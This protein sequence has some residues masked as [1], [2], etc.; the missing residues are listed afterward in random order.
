MMDGIQLCSGA[1]SLDVNEDGKLDMVLTFFNGNDAWWFPNLGGGNFDAPKALFN[2]L[3]SPTNVHQTMLTDL[4]ADGRIDYI[5]S[6]KTTTLTK[7]AWFRNLGN[8][9]FDAEKTLVSMGHQGS[10]ATPYFTVFDATL[11]GLPDLVVSDNYW[12]RFHLL[13]SAGNG[14]FSASKVVYDEGDFGDFYGVVGHDVDGDGRLDLVYGNRTENIN[15]QGYE[16]LSWLRNLHPQPVVPFSVIEKSATCSDNQTPADAT[17]DFLTISLKIKG[18]DNSSTRFVLSNFKTGAV[19]DTFIYDEKIELQLPPGS[20]GD[21]VL[22]E[23]KIQDLIFQ[24]TFLV[25]GFDAGNPCSAAAS[26]AILISN[27]Q[28]SCHDS[29]TPDDPTDDR[30]V[31]G[32]TP[33]LFN[34]TIQSLHFYISSNFGFAADTLNFGNLGSYGKENY[35]VLP[36][37]S[38]AVEG[39]L[40]LTLQ[41]AFD[42]NNIQQFIFDHPGTCSGAPL[43]C[44]LSINY[45]K[46]SEIDLFPIKYP[47]CRVLPGDLTLEELLPD[48]G[49]PRIENLLGFQQMLEVRGDVNISRT[50]LKNLVGLDSLQLVGRD[51]NVLFFNSPTLESLVGL[52]SLRKIGRD[53]WLSDTAATLKNLAGMENLDTVG[54]DLLLWQMA[55]VKNF[56]GLENLKSAGIVAYNCAALENLTGL[57]HLESAHSISLAENQNLKSLDGLENLKTIAGDT[58]S[59]LQIAKNPLLDDLSALDHTVSIPALEIW[60]NPKLSICAV[61][62]ICNYLK[63]FDPVKTEIVDNLADCNSILEVQN[64]CSVSTADFSQK[65]DF[66]VSPNPLADDEPLQILL[67]NDFFGTVKFEILSLDGRVLQVFKKEKTAKKQVFEIENLPAGNSFFVSVSDE[68]RSATRLVFKY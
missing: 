68:K 40:I 60:E 49:V 7:V 34:P 9:T 65:F 5:Y 38:A 3:P 62:A 26:A 66:Q 14:K 51:L 12:N 63:N 59:I 36:P 50:N 55:G 35:F 4:D 23:F 43:P 37:G 1:F 25:V 19:V 18:F 21:G 24:D 46:Q 39:K 41:D 54:N 56:E 28:I 47:G 15:T 2:G 64:G 53:I 57:E 17:D 20:A 8:S 32:F 45:H 52:G 31:V 29:G 11:D 13:S 22:K 16:Q 42:F 30:L 33:K 27:V 44:P 6:T 61:E 67:E 48:A 10:Y 58:F